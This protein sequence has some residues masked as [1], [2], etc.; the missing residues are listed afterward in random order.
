[1]GVN[2]TYKDSVFSFLFSNPDTLRE[3]YG[4]ITGAAL[5]PEVPI[6]I[7]TLE[8]VLYRTLRNDISFEVGEKLVVLIEHQSSINPNMAIRL[9]MYMGRVY[10]KLTAR[11]NIYG[12]KKLKIPRPEFIVLYNGKAPYPEE[13]VLHLS[14]AFE[15]PIVPGVGGPKLELEVKVYNINYGCNEELVRRS[16]TLEGY[17]RFIAKVR[18]LERVGDREGAMGEAVKW[19][20]GQGILKGFLEEHGTE[21][22]NMLMAEWKLED[23]LVVEREEGRDEGREECRNMVLELVRQGYSAEQIEAKLAAGESSRTETAGK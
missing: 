4:A 3:L 22:M 12:S 9:L 23:A 20:I 2:T 13:G 16:E 7:N 1:M 21:V 19:C 6:T 8:G 18:E 5:P 15:E 11:K 14:D 17:S 10:E